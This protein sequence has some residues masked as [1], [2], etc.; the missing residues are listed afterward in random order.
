[1]S[2]EALCDEDEWEY[3]DDDTTLSDLWQYLKNECLED[4]PLAFW[5][6]T[7]LIDL[8]DSIHDYWRLKVPM[9]LAPGYGYTSLDQPLS[10]DRIKT[11]LLHPLEAYICGNGSTREIFQVFLDAH[12]I[13]LK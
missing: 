9:I 11:S 8:P 12:T 2:D 3:Y 7:P 1:M 10:L 6:K 5:L 13:W 4:D